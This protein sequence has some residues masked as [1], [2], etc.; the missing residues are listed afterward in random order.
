MSIHLEEII[1]NPLAWK[2][3]Y[4]CLYACLLAPLIWLQNSFL[5]NETRLHSPLLRYT[6][7]P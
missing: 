2:T 3:N 1:R 7:V 6:L 5:A 4:Y